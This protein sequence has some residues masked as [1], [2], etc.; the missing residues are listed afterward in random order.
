[1]VLKADE[2]RRRA[3]LLD[4][5]LKICSCADCEFGGAPQPIANFSRNKNTGDGLQGWC[6]SCFQ[7]YRRSPAGKEAN[8]QGNRRYTRSEK[9]RATRAAYRNSPAGREAIARSHDRY[10]GTK[11]HRASQRRYYH[12]AKGTRTRKRYRREHVMVIRAN[13]VVEKAIRAGEL[14]HVSESTCCD[15]GITAEVYHHWSYKRIHWLDVIPLCR[16]CHA[17]RH[18]GVEAKLPT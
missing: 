15:C 4:Q 11:K 5:G 14:A 16:K 17:A 1:M 18:A 7:R 2:M 3:E 9:G 12:S 6:K 8:R 10:R 13:T